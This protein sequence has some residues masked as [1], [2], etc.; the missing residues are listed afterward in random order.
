MSGGVLDNVDERSEGGIDQIC[1][2]GDRETERP[3][4][5]IIVFELWDILCVIRCG[6]VPNLNFPGGINGRLA[7]V[8]GASDIREC[9]DV[10]G[11]RVTSWHHGLGG[12]E[13]HDGGTLHECGGWSSSTVTCDVGTGLSCG[14]CMNTS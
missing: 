4:V 8:G 1:W 6:C 3:S 11:G 12:V 10:V 5:V 7:Y 2:H 14:H 9:M 13:L